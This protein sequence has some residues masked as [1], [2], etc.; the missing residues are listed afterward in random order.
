MLKK[1]KEIAFLFLRIGSIAFG[2]PLAHIAIF[3]R[4]IIEK[5]KWITNEH[6]ANLIGFTNL[7]PGP[8]STEMAIYIGKERGGWPGM[9]LAGVCFILPATLFTMVLAYLYQ[10]YGYL[11][12]FQS[13]IFGL[14]PAVIS[15]IV[16]A[17]YPLARKK[18]NSAAMI[19]VFI[20]VLSLAILGFNPII[21]LFG[22][23][24]FYAIFYYTF[25]IK[26]SKGAKL[27]TFGLFP[28]KMAVLF[29]LPNL[30]IFLSFLKI[31]A[32]LYGG[33]YVLFAFLDAEFVSKGI[34][35]KNL[36]MDSIAV[37]Q[38]T[39]GPILSTATFIGW[40]LNGFWGG[41]LATIGVFLPSFIFI[42]IINP[43]LPRLRKSKIFSSFLDAVTV[44]SFAIIFFVCLNMAKTIIYDWRCDLIL[45]ATLVILL[46][47]KKINSGLVVFSSIIFGY[48]LSLI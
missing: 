28:Q 30:S 7:I 21:L 24:I 11:P 44:A 14:K 31:G 23:G 48:I 3:Q 27:L 47:Y 43:L 34:I 33:G 32:I 13:V 38:F 46:K 4:E 41:L 29:H 10:M 8:N 18:T 5:R 37:G 2:G 39:P 26:N 19:I 25:K 22:S 6:F 9:I 15:I 17:I 20:I 42:A 36:L 1:L 35:T 45:I 40:Q 16:A 12:G